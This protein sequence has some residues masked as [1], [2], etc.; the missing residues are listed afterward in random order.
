MA[1][2]WNDL[3]LIP[4]G[5]ETM[6]APGLEKQGCQGVGGCWERKGM[7]EREDNAA[8]RDWRRESIKHLRVLAGMGRKPERSHLL[9]FFY[10]P[11]NK[12]LGYL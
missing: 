8:R 10:P 4:E 12:L 1:G 5:G 3:L 7:C 6:Q 9:F 2:S 11:S